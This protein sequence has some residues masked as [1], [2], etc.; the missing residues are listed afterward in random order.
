MSKDSIETQV[1]NIP[2]YTLIPSR[3]YIESKLCDILIDSE[4]NPSIKPHIEPPTE[5]HFNNIPNKNSQISALKRWILANSIR[6]DWGIGKSKDIYYNAISDFNKS[7][8]L[9]SAL[10]SN[11]YKEI[12]DVYDPNIIPFNGKKRLHESTLFESMI[13]CIIE[14]DNA[15]N[16][17]EAVNNII[18]DFQISDRFVRAIYPIDYNQ[19]SKIVNTGSFESRD[20]DIINIDSNFTQ[21]KNIDIKNNISFGF[22]FL[23]HAHRDHFTNF[24]DQWD[25]LS[26]G[27]NIICSKITADIAEIRYGLKIPP[28]LRVESGTMNFGQSLQFKIVPSGHTIGSSA[29]CIGQMGGILEYLI[30][31]EFRSEPM[32]P[33]TED[34]NKLQ[35]VLEPRKCKNLIIDST[36][37]D[38]SIK[39]PPIQYERDKM[40]D[41]MTDSLK[42]HSIIIYAYE[43]GKAQ[44]ISAII[45]YAKLDEAYPVVM[46]QNTYQLNSYFL[47]RGYPMVRAFTKTE[48]R[49]K[50]IISG[51]ESSKFIMIIPRSE[52]KL[53]ATRVLRDKYNC[54]EAEVSGWCAY[55]KW[56]SDHEADEYFIISDHP[57]C[58]TSEK[59][60]KKCEPENV[61]RY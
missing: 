28:N 29:L 3:S 17:Q 61:I 37:T 14:S 27:A 39:F 19:A 52:K 53:P 51:P 21:P 56:R 7:L 44:D 31:G 25:Y 59:F 45:R 50:K 4:L 54:L 18:H 57:D 46:N 48:A 40:I 42:S 20:E 2:L 43:Y 34:F 58:E 22:S 16:I 9:L 33:E 8:D 38:P 36:F 47:E 35:T 5:T 10:M 11:Q 55:A 26:D 32:F 12:S 6:I 23:S 30:A 41:W 1:E 24:L 60:I 13:Q 49:S 15:A